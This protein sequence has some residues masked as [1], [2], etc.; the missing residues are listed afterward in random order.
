MKF[1]DKYNSL[2]QYS[3]ANYLSIN[4][5]FCALAVPKKKAEK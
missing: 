5:I 3:R 1:V 4:K 2:G